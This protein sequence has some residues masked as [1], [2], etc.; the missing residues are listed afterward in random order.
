MKTRPIA[1]QSRVTANIAIQSPRFRGG[2]RDE[3][4]VIVC[5]RSAQPRCLRVFAAERARKTRPDARAS[6]DEPASPRFR[7]G[8]REENFRMSR[9]RASGCRSVS[10]FSRRSARGK[11]LPIFS[12]FIQRNSPH[13]RALPFWRFCAAPKRLISQSGSRR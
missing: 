3:N 9:E 1:R 7:G 6:A 12:L 2:A 4:D 13:L 10:A 8:A 5:L 11:L